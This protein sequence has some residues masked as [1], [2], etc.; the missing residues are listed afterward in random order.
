MAGGGIILALFIV[1]VGVFCT[2]WYFGASKREVLK[3]EAV[4]RQI[5][6][7]REL[8]AEQNL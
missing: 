2:F 8:Q 3:R 7:E 4:E 6:K 5:Q 1:Y